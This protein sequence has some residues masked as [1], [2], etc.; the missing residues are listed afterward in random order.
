MDPNFL[1]TVTGI[2]VEQRIIARLGKPIWEKSW[3]LFGV[4]Y[5]CLREAAR[6]YDASANLAA[7]VMARGAVEGALY[8]LKYRVRTGDNWV[9]TPPTRDGEF[10]RPK[11]PDLA[12]NAE[13]VLGPSPDR[14]QLIE[15]IKEDGDLSAHVVQREDEK[16]LELMEKLRAGVLLPT[17]IGWPDNSRSE[18]NIMDA[19]DIVCE[20]VLSMLAVQGATRTGTQEIR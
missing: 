9:I 2:R 12:K 13:A 1:N 10:S 11:F 6:C 7:C 20:I 8:V 15:R 17:Q 18:H 4:T 3:P 16:L 5:V 19:A 14:T